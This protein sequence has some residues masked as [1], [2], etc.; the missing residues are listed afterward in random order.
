MSLLWHKWLQILVVQIL[1]SGQR[2]SPGGRYTS[3]RQVPLYSVT[4]LILNVF[5]LCFFKGLNRLGNLLSELRT[6]MQPG[7]YLHKSSSVA[8]E[9]S[10]LKTLTPTR[11]DDIFFFSEAKAY[12]DFTPYSQHRMFLDGNF[13]QTVG[14]Y[15]QAQK[16]LGNPEIFAEIEA[17]NSASKAWDIAH[18]AKHVIVS[19]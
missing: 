18:D 8:P 7:G 3:Y 6:S 12:F 11:H 2:V 17:C 19:L 1:L 5:I 16:F 14:H 15:F 13:W 10:P 4:T 9:T